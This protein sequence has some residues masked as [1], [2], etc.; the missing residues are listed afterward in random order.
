[1]EDGAVD[2]GCPWQ[3][4]ARPC[5]FLMSCVHT[6]NVCKKSIVRVLLSESLSCPL[7]VARVILSMCVCYHTYMPL[8]EYVAVPVVATED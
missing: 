7:P 3:S 8:P 6:A 2:G 5:L 1:M 4:S